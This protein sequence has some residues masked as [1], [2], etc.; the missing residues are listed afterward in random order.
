MRIKQFIFSKQLT[1]SFWQGISVEL[2]PKKIEVEM[3][4]LD[5]KRMWSFKKRNDLKLEMKKK[6]IEN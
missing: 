6:T 4:S 1:S 2:V 3:Y 5:S